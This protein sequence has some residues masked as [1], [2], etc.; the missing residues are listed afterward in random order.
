[1][2]KAVIVGDNMSKDRNS[3]TL[4]LSKR[5]YKDAQERG[6]LPTLR[7]IENYELSVQSTSSLRPYLDKGA[8]Q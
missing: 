5:E 7:G 2:F 6:G 8:R 4:I 1:M 3:S